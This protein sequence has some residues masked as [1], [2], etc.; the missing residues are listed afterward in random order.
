M[1]KLPLAFMGLS[2]LFAPLQVLSSPNIAALKCSNKKQCATLSRKLKKTAK[3]G[4][5]TSQTLLA[6]SY[7]SGEL[8]KVDPQRA[9]RWLKRSMKKRYAP[10][11]FIAATWYAE[12]YHTEVDPNKA[13]ELLNLSAEYGYIRAKKLLKILANKNLESAA[14]EKVKLSKE[15]A[16]S[17]TLT[18]MERIEVTYTPQERLKLVLDYQ[19]EI[20]YDQPLG[21]TGTH[22]RGFR[23]GEGPSGMSNSKVINANSL[24]GN[25]SVAE[26]FR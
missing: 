11:Y 17:S 7:R 8:S 1:D 22:I 21:S 15:K 23:F 20:G 9:W 24:V 18:N 14:N 4:S 26:A 25:T 6:L 2:M 5:P 12:G 13:A 19:L 10:A 3:A 16:S